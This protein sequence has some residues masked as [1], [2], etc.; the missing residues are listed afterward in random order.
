MNAWISSASPTATATVIT[1]SITCL[2]P[3]FGSVAPDF[4]SVAPDFAISR[5]RSA[6]TRRSQRA[7][8][9]RWPVCEER[10]A[11]DPRLAHRAPEAAVV[12]LTAVVAHHVVLV[13]RDRD[14]SWEV[15][16]PGGTAG[17]I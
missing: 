15:A 12:G 1:S 5:R 2:T 9:V 13:R 16:R 14:R 4:G 3:D 8:P 6:G 7:D 17:Q 11:D 10:L